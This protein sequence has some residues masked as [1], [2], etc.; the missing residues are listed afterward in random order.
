MGSILRHE[1]VGTWQ[2]VSWTQRRGLEEILPMGE[3]P[4]GSIIYTEDGFISV[5][6]MRRQRAQMLSG[7][8]V[9]ASEQEKAVAFGDY[10]GYAGTFELDGEDVVHHINCASFPNWV[11]QRQTRRPRLEGGI[12]TLD[13]A[14]RIVSGVSV[15]ATLVWRRVNA[16][17]QS[18]KH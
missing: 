7:D 10:L 8:F 9:T 3:A 14:A 13:A 4:V 11:G 5:N 18:Q 17:R 12:L 15:T 1:L 2:M 16:N 6:I